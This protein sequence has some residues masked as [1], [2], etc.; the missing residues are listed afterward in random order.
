MLPSGMLWGDCCIV[1]I[2]D[3][4]MTLRFPAYITDHTTASSGDCALEF[5]VGST[6]PVSLDFLSVFVRML[7]LQVNKWFVSVHLGSRQERDGTC[8]I[9]TLRRTFKRYHLER[10][11]QNFRKPQTAVQ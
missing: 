4:L 3:A 7:C 9:G 2:F 1:S 6:P 8:R 5:R 10:N 11:G